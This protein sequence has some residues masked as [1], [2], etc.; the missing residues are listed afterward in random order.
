[1]RVPQ[2]FWEGISTRDFEM[3]FH[4]HLDRYRQSRGARRSKRLLRTIQ[5]L[6][7]EPRLQASCNPAVTATKISIIDRLD[8]VINYSQRNGPFFERVPLATQEKL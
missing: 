7:L 5:R 2:A 4:L 8:I 1:M 3:Q 6:T